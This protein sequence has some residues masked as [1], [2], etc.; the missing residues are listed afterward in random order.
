MYA[1]NSRYV[2]TEIPKHIT[3][4]IVWGICRVTHCIAYGSVLNVDQYIKNLCTEMI[5]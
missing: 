5:Y 1:T 4:P 2:R 3:N